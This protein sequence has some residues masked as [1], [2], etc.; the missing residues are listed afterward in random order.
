MVSVNKNWKVF[1]IPQCPS[2]RKGG[3]GGLLIVAVLHNGFILRKHFDT[4][5]SPLERG[6]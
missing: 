3:E 1:Y 2:L 6:D 5:F 4:L